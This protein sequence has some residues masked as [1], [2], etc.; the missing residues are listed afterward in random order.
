MSTHVDDAVAVK[1]LTDRA[2][3]GGVPGVSVNG[4]NVIKVREAA[5]Q[6]VKR[7]GQGAVPL[8]SNARHTDF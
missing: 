8:L 7:H 4:N 6:A 3:G 5:I 1:E 2:K